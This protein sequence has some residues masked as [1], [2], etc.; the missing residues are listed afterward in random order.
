MIRIT[1]YNNETLVPAKCGSRFL[2]TIWENKTDTST[3]Y[4]SEINNNIK[5]IIVRNPFEHLSS[6][7]HTDILH[8]WNREWVNVDESIILKKYTQIDDGS[9]Y[10]LNLYK[11][12]YNFWDKNNRTA[13]IV[14]LDD[15]TDFIK[16]VGVPYNFDVNDY[17]WK[18]IFD[19]WKTKEEIMDY[20][21][22]TYPEIY[23]FLMEHIHR[24]IDFYNKMINNE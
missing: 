14:K 12:L 13:Q 17:N 7:L 10:Q 15:L 8:I 6:A 24:E 16:N 21:K 11:T 22:E 2:D 9:H 4:L 1:I 20:V 3:Y 5:T 18:P 19:I 23:D